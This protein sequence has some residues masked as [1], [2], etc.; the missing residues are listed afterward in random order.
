MKAVIFLKK[1]IG[2]LLLILT[3]I[4]GLLNYDKYGI[5]WDEE[6]QREMGI[7]SY[8]Y[9]FSDSKVLTD[10]VCRSYG[11]AFEL[12]LVIIEK[13]IGIQDSRDIYLLRHLLTHLF[14]LIG[15][16][17]GF[18]LID[19]LYK[20]KLLASFGFL[21]IILNPIL[22]AH[23]FFNTKDIPSAAMFLICFYLIAIAF[24]KQ[25]IRYFL[26]L[27]VGI[28][29]LINIRIMGVLLFCCI[30]FFLLLDFFIKK[31]DKI[32]NKKRIKLLLAFII[33]TILTL[34]VSWPFLWEKPISNFIFAFEN[35]S[36]FPWSSSL[37]YYGKFV[38]A[39]KLGWEYIPVWF[40]ITTPIYY[41]IAGFVGVFIL[42][43]NFVKTPFAFLSNTKNRNNLYFLICF[44]VPVIAV[45]VLKSVVYDG[46]R[47]LYFIYP[48]FVLLAIYG[49]N[50][51]LHT[52]FKKVVISIT[53]IFFCYIGYFMIE[54]NPFQNVY[55]NELVDNKSPERIRKKFELD[56][57][58][59][60]YKQSLEYILKEDNSPKINV[61]VE[62]L[63]GKYNIV[64]LPL[65]DR[66]RINFVEVQDAKYFITNYR[67]HPE[68]YEE[69]KQY[70]W[71]SF[72]VNN[73]TINE[74]FKLK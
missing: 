67:W 41:I 57:W 10:Y 9:V 68:D 28:G 72:K 1:N 24:S 71:H 42:V 35:M 23:S 13:A 25:K 26:L 55:F 52:K 58:G 11:V 53:V 38:L 43:F 17:F 39:T 4:I 45:I 40:G 27:G 34:Y 19:F 3:F 30:L 64:I 22:Y 47:H 70:K 60:S 32:D 37:L 6:I 73:N 69:F 31:E 59:T 15:A 14:F 66:N 61:A 16:F 44:F 51:M 74:I 21:L 46:W 62:N 12:P 54:N 50:F 36:K 49:I 2:I 7:V 20:N 33:A 48:S 18:L 29:L 56:Y 8:N 5:A 63:P 65:K